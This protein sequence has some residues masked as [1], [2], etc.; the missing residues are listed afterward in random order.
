M[1]TFQGITDGVGAFVAFFLV[2]LI[3]QYSDSHGRKPAL[4][5]TMLSASAPLLVLAA[6]ESLG[7]AEASEAVAL[8]TIVL[9]ALV[10]LFSKLNSYAVALSYVADCS[11]LSVRPSA[12]AQVSGVMFIGLTAGPLCSSRMNRTAA[13]GVAAGLTVLT[14]IYLVVMT[15]ESKSPS[16][17]GSPHDHAPLL[18]SSTS[19]AGPVGASS[20]DHLLVN[21]DKKSYGSTVA[22]SPQASPRPTIVKPTKGSLLLTFKFL[23]THPIYMLIGI[24]T[25]LSQLAVFGVGQI[26][27]LYL[28]E[29]LSFQ[30]SDN[31]EA[32]WIGGAETTL[33]MIGVVPYASKILHESSI[34]AFGL[35]CYAIYALGLA[36]VAS[37][38]AQALFII[39][40]WAGSGV[41]F[42][43]TC[44]LLS[45]LTSAEHTGLA[46]GAL[47]AIRSF[48]SGLGPA[49]FA[50]FFGQMVSYKHA[51]LHTTQQIGYD[52]DSAMILGVHYTA[53]PF[54]VGT[55]LILAALVLTLYLPSTHPSLPSASP[56]ALH[57]QHEQQKSISS[58]NSAAHQHHD[59]WYFLMR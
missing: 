8:G 44:A 26:Y 52:Q 15:P 21:S 40:F 19:T 23:T 41:L 31:I 50:L 1:Q 47:S 24:I 30:R 3:G 55:V 14:A 57:L 6:Y 11:S 43:A 13:L 29:E 28:L 42:P 18:S 54:L 25:L 38:R 58:L 53:I 22:S 33:L 39:I 56:A 45:S 32:A 59:G 36:I 37:T 49:L 7:G 9:Y 16:S 10:A 4:L 46:Q 35:A 12:F 48:A 17:G 5:F 34:M 27:Y 20:Q 2:P 51:A